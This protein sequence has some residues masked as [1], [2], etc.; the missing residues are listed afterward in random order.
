[1]ITVG[2]Q[3]RVM[4]VEDRF[5]AQGYGARNAIHWPSS[6]LTSEVAVIP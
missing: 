2:G 3:P 5:L 1:M 4:F 6:I